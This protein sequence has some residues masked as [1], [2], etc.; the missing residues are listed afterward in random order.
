MPN[1]PLLLV[2]L[3]ACQFPNRQDYLIRLAA[4]N[5]YRGV[6]HLCRELKVRYVDLLFCEP[7]VFNAFIAGRA[8]RPELICSRKRQIWLV[9]LGLG[10]PARICPECVANGLPQSQVFNSALPILCPIHSLLP[11]DLCPEC[12]SGIT[13]LRISIDRCKCGYAFR[14]GPVITP[15]DWLGKL[16]QACAPW[17]LADGA[18]K[19]VVDFERESEAAIVAYLLLH[20]VN[21]VKIEEAIAWI[22]MKHYQLLEAVFSN[23][24]AG[25]EDS[26]YRHL[27]SLGKPER[28]RY[29]SYLKKKAQPPVQHALE[30]SLRRWHCGPFHEMG[31]GSSCF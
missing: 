16:Y 9:R 1:S 10:S 14:N 12:G 17:H 7:E 20:Q 22:S 31:L 29:I 18:A 27:D 24:P 19:C 25:I 2:R 8:T 30:V 15:P 21:R 28:V 26:I 4:E 13:Y 3:D 6:R 11:F 23:W 5:R